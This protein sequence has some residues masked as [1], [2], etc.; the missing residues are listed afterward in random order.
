MLDK[1]HSVLRHYQLVHSREIFWCV[2]N[3][4]CHSPEVCVTLV[5]NEI[6]RVVVNQMNN[7]DILTR[8]EAIIAVGNVLVTLRPEHVM[9]LLEQYGD[10]LTVYLNG[11]Q[12]ISSE[13]VI[14]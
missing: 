3:I 14:L 4:A 8:K 11:L 10:L 12:L 6:F 2:G 1:L 9:Q 5:N 13:D 7:P